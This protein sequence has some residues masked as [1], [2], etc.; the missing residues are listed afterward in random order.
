MCSRH[1]IDFGTPKLLNFYFESLKSVNQITKKGPI[2][3][4]QPKSPANFAG[5][6]SDA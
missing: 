3:D 4:V 5:P 1:P 6:I 2:D